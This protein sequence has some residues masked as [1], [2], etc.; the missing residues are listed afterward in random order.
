MYGPLVRLSQRPRERHRLTRPPASLTSEK[1]EITPM[2]RQSAFPLVF[3]A[4]LTLVVFPGCSGAGAASSG[5]ESAPPAAEDVASDQQAQSRVLPGLEVVL[6]DS[7]HL[8]RG[9]RVGFITNQTAV[10]ASGG[11]GI[12]LLHEAEDVELVALYGPEH[13][14]RGNVEGGVKIDTGRDEATGIP[15]CTAI[16]AEPPN[17]WT[18]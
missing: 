12:D 17:S 18:G 9:R 7:M 10:T 1:I 3:A 11:S 15:S 8:L 6:R 2:Q 13:G 5:E 16:C 14:L 4:C